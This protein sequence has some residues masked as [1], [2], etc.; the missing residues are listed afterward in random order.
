VSFDKQNFARTVSEQQAGISPQMWPIKIDIGGF[1]GPTT[2]GLNSPFE[3]DINPCDCIWLP[4]TYDK[5]YGVNPIQSDTTWGPRAGLPDPSVAGGNLIQTWESQAN[6]YQVTPPVFG[7][8]FNS[9]NNP[10]LLW[11]LG[12][13]RPGP[14]PLFG[15]ETGNLGAGQFRFGGSSLMRSITGPISRMWCQYYAWGQVRYS[16]APD[17]YA[18]LYQQ[19]I[20]LSMLGFSQESRDFTQPVS[21]SDAVAIPSGP[22]PEMWSSTSCGGYRT[23]DLNSADLRALGVNPMAVAPTTAGA[24][25]TSG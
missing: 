25:S 12:T 10:W 16:P 15:I 23:P 1:P 24:G 14:A 9:P 5:S 11:G 3:I 22:P 21:N 8:R 18:S 13:L 19:I 2:I 6:Y 17:D 4:I 7:L 20:L